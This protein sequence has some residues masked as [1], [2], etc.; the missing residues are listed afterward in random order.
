MKKYYIILLFAVFFVQHGYSQFTKYPNEVLFNWASPYKSYSYQ[1]QHFRI[2]YPNDFDSLGTKKYPV[3]LFLHGFGERGTDNENQ[4]KHGGQR[5]LNA[6]NSGEFPGIAFYPQTT[7]VSWDGS[8]LQSVVAILDELIAKCNA[9]PDR[10]YVHGLSLGAEGVWRFAFQYPQYAAAIFPMSGVV[11]GNVAGVTRFIPTWLSQGGLDKNPE[12]STGNNRVISWREQ[13]AN[14]RYSYMPTTGHG[15]WN[16]QYSKSE[17][18]PW[19]LEKHKTDITV[20]YGQSSFCENDPID[21]TLGITAGFAN[22]QWVKNDTTST[23]YIATGSGSN[24]INVTDIGYYYV[25]FQ[26]AN[27][28]WTKW[29]KPVHVN[30]NLNKTS[31]PTTSF[32][33]QSLNL[34]TIAG[35]QSVEIT[36]PQN[37]D[38]YR[39]FRNATIIPGAT[40]YVFTTS[41]G[42]EYAV[43]VRTEKESSWQDE[44][45]TVPSEFQAPPQPCF[46]DPSEPLVVTSQNGLNVPAK[47]T[48]FFVNLLNDNSIVINW[49]DNSSDELAFELYRSVQSGSGY[50]LVQRINA[51]TGANPQSYVDTPLN[52]NTNYFYRMRAVNNS[53]GS[54][55]TREESASTLVDSESPS[56]PFLNLIGSTTNSVSVEWTASTD[57]IGVVGYEVFRN[58]A[59]IASLPNDQFQFTNTGLAIDQ[60]YSYVVKAKD[61]TGNV[62][63]ASN[64]VTAKTSVSQG[65]K[66]TYYH[67]NNFNSVDQ[68]VSNGTVIKTGIVNNFNMNNREREDRFAFI[69]EGLV[70]IPTAGDYTFF[71]N[72]DDGSKLFIN[73]QLIVDNDGTHGCQQRNGVINLPVG[74]AAI[75]VLMFENGGG[76]CLEVRWQG[77]GISKQFIPDNRLFNNSFELSGFPS[78]PSNLQAT[79]IS[80][81]QIDLNWTDNSNNEEGFEIYRSLNQNANYQLVHLSAAN[82]TSWTDSDL[83]GGTTY[84]YKIKAINF[85]GSSD[86]T[87]PISATTTGNPPSPASPANF[88]LIVENSSN[89]RLNWTDNAT[90]ELGYEVYRST[91]SVVSTFTLI[92]TTSTNVNSYLDQQ[93]QGNRTYYYRIRAKGEGSFSDFTSVLNITTDNNPP[94]IESIINRSVKYGTTLELPIIANDPDGDPITFSFSNALPA[95]MSLSD[96]G[97]GRA[98]LTV[99]SDISNAGQYPLEISANDGSGGVDTQ[100]FVIT[101][102]DNENPFISSIDNIIMK[103]GYTVTFD[104]A[105]ID[106]TLGS[107]TLSVS[108]KPD[109]VFF[110]D[111]GGGIGTFTISTE[112]NQAGVF[113]N[114]K[115]LADDGNGGFS[116]ESFNINIEEAKRNYSV[117]VNFGTNVAPSPW[118]NI[119]F[120]NGS[121]GE[122]FIESNDGGEDVV[123]SNTGQ[124]YNS[125]GNS[126]LNSDLY[127]PEVV[128]YFLRKNAGNANFQLTNLN[129]GLNYDITFF[130]GKLNNNDGLSYTRTRFT[131]NGTSKF[132]SVLNNTSN[133]VVFNSLK[134]DENGVLNIGVQ[135]EN[136]G[137]FILNSMEVNVYYEDG[138]PPAAPTNLTLTAISNSEV[139][140]SWEDNA[141]NEQRFEIFRSNVS[142]TGPFTQVG[143]APLNQ[144]TFF[145]ENLN[146]NTTYYYKVRAV[147]S[148]GNAETTVAFI[149][150]QNSAPV[151]TNIENVTISVGDTLSIAFSA[152]DAENDGIIF[153]AVS[154]PDFVELVDNNDGT[155]V[156][157]IIPTGKDAGFYGN[158]IVEATDIYGLSAQ[159]L[160]NIQV[161]DNVF[162]NTFYLNFGNNS[163][164]GSPWNNISGSFAQGTSYNSLLNF[165][166]IA[167]NVGLEIGAGWSA[168][169]S[170][171]MSSG[172]NSFILEDIVFQNYWRSNNS[173]ASLKLTGLDT[174]KLYTIELLSSSNAWLNTETNFTVQNKSRNNV[175]VTKNKDNLLS[176]SGVKPNLAGEITISLAQFNTITEAMFIN[177]LILK[178]NI[179]D[180]APIAPS[181]FEARGISKTEIELKWQ[182]NAVN[183]TGYEIYQSDEI[184]K[185]FTLLA[186]TGPDV[187]YY[188]HTGLIANAPRIY[189]I[190]AV[191]I[192]GNSEY[193]PEIAA[194]TL[195]NK[196]FINVN[197]D[198]SDYLQ[199]GAPWN[200]TNKVPTTGLVF[201]NLVD[202][203]SNPVP[204]QMI[205]EDI[206]DGSNNKN[207]FTS[208]DL[209]YPAAVM[210][211]YYYF[212]PNAAPGLFRLSNLSDSMVYDLTFMGSHGGTLFAITDYTVGEKTVTGFGKSNRYRTS[213]IHDVTPD[214]NST[215]LFEVDAS[216]EN[217]AQYGL[218]NSLV[219]EEHRSADVALDKIA[220]SVPQNLVANNI[221]ENSLDLLW[222]TASDNVSLSGYE[223]YQNGV[224]IATTK[225][226][227][228]NVANLVP[229][230]EY[231]FTVRSVDRNSNHSAFSNDLK[232]STSDPADG[233]ITYYSLPSGSLN[234]PGTWNTQT[235]GSGTS[236][237]DFT[238]NNNEFILNRTATLSG[239]WTISGTGS[240]LIVS[241]DVSLT[242][243]AGFE[244]AISALENAGIFINVDAA[245]EFVEMHPSSTVSFNALNNNIPTSAYGNLILGGNTGATKQFRSGNLTIEGTLSVEDGVELNGVDPNSTNIVAKG[246]VSFHGVGSAIPSEKMLSLVMAGTGEQHIEVLNDNINLFN[247]RI[248]EGA[249]V[250]FDSNNPEMQIQLGNASGGGLV[251]EEGASLNIGHHNLIIDGRGIINSQNQTGRLKTNN[252]SLEFR[253]RSTLTSHLHFEA[254]SDTL[255]MLLTDMANSGKIEI[256][257][258]LYISDELQVRDGIVDA[259]GNLT[260]VSDAEGTA[261]ISEIQNRGEI[262]G[263]IKAQRYVSAPPNRMY[264]YF[265]STVRNAT[266]ADWQEHIAITGNFSGRSTG[267]G[268][269]A[270]PSVHYYD[271]NTVSGW[272]P[273]PTTSNQ[274]IMEVGKGFSVFTRDTKNPLRLELVGEPVQGDF[275][276]NLLAEGT[277]DPTANDGVG[278]G[279]NLVA[280]PYQSPIQWGGEG[281][282]S[283]NLS[284]VLSIWDADYPGGGKYFYAGGGVSDSSFNGEVAIGQGFW[285]QAI[286]SNPQLIISESAKVNTNSAVFYRN[287]VQQPVQFTIRLAKD[288]I[289]DK[290]FILYSEAGSRIY[291]GAIHGRKRTNDIF[292]IATASA[293]GVDL[294]VNHL[295]NNFCS[296]SIAILTSNLA[297]GNYKIS[298]EK[299]ETFHDNEEFTLIDHFLQTEVDVTLQTSYAFDVEHAGDPSGVGRFTLIIRKP[300][301]DQSLTLTQSSQSICEDD[302]VTLTIKGSQKNALYS[303]IVNGEEQNN[304]V[305]ATGNDLTLVIDSEKLNY[306]ENVVLVEAGFRNCGVK[307]LNNSIVIER[308]KQPEVNPVDP[309][310]I[311]S[312]NSAHITI[313]PTA[314][315]LSF[316]WYSDEF[317]EDPILETSSLQFE[318]PVLNSS[319]AYY[320]AAVNSNGCESS[321]RE[322]IEILV[323]K[324]DE[325]VINFKDGSLFSSSENGNQ[326]YFNGQLIED[327]IH[328]SLPVSEPGVYSVKVSNGICEIISDNYEYY[329]TSNT[330]SATLDLNI[331]PNP[332]DQD[333]NVV[334]NQVLEEDVLV[335]IVDLAGR[336]VYSDIV[337]KGNKESVVMVNHLSSGTYVVRMMYMNKV[338][339]KRLLVN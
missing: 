325:P 212:E 263:K 280:N 61:A 99:N 213:T 122:R 294:A 5:T 284:P 156:L 296:D 338:Y 336:E 71:T 293:D 274:E 331:Y 167:G 172:N 74:L 295:P 31:Q 262:R 239:E 53:G 83:S 91:S 56:A 17:F 145:D 272:M 165:N 324:L 92:H 236:P 187:E 323:E 234:S 52:A 219:I 20:L 78:Q 254:G 24:T 197:T 154:L 329:I 155:G 298:F 335:K 308:S 220:P 57:N 67:H 97:Y 73:N 312:G 297:P 207:G 66:Y 77:P 321:K 248:G 12:P 109:F 285:V 316:R 273:F 34:P 177:A 166:G 204:I 35:Q 307:V 133:T 275:E 45:E 105:V 164:A 138:L 337:R 131:I 40:N 125:Y 333:F 217:D 232:I 58:N 314:S 332:A 334:F 283:S 140:L 107:L 149:T 130:A 255:K 192:D 238:L 152:T 9:D 118:N 291:N 11:G 25:R 269:T 139:E 106:E 6:I 251:I 259:Q 240:K 59:L 270:N 315:N 201:N 70:E 68:I 267:P 277:N 194:V 46:S 257:S 188:K 227:S 7:G 29:S 103:E 174:E 79:I 94:V 303:L 264:R 28:V 175:N 14:I 245:P 247:L 261:Y 209:I 23:N 123:L 256:N 305:K 135:G 116:E 249:E 176:F 289:E 32:G 185:A 147:N 252:G 205:I 117:F 26:R 242:I 72:S 120:G 180:V 64:Q 304:M 286:D 195:N 330:N 41:N 168:T 19:F 114:I 111:L 281:W 265:G 299:L 233:F 110:E 86:F 161:I 189:K 306:G 51:T 69:F 137:N 108:N 3:I 62:S 311:C 322:V 157:T 36:G 85:N 43:S 63:L 226:A 60:T 27:G 287:A 22:Y 228:L 151:L 203:T 50:K 170:D 214:D 218:F 169:A 202:F 208:G 190:R 1:G 150:T 128:D 95:F 318:S 230:Y 198:I 268:L 244:G 48:N 181:K 104:V 221:T 326:W 100:S 179:I 216:N 121:K 200:N 81:S 159:T 15:T 13:G 76:Q 279:W 184:G 339:M 75:R 80:N 126:T 84:Y 225:E 4:L 309:I 292:N 276:F 183:E 90:A 258:P 199:A 300:E 93:T 2:K 124:W 37:M 173:S 319:T 301:I 271:E 153:T 141:N 163:N 171:G 302:Q 143:F 186:T 146:G 10:I 206:G 317:D 30:R 313:N 88:S 182:D 144:T 42:G 193:T 132:L 127:I 148:T 223:V 54:E 278:D 191:G 49:D 243:D 235:D 47:P 229:G 260:M 96:N 82:E 320:Y 215:I 158:N 55:Y 241:N 39:W 134:P 210:Q 196:I 310:T 65:L 136:S 178:E 266:V 224:M 129:P 237:A 8:N 21:I 222:N 119:S 282:T 290:A 33:N 250:V 253:S 112:I 246:T 87:G 38:S 211:A 142:E 102:S 328:Q 18:F 231:L 113:N 115:L 98:Q 101:I 16:A 160:F 288:G 44:A 327:A 89:V 162:A